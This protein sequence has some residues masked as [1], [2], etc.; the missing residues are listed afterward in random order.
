MVVDVSERKG[1]LRGMG[2]VGMRREE[3]PG[4]N[5]KQDVLIE[6]N[7]AADDR[8]RAWRDG[9]G[10]CQQQGSGDPASGSRRDHGANLVGQR[11]E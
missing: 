11:D 4:A 10:R 6:S 8:G 3:R 1:V 2:R 7:V 9:E 5:R